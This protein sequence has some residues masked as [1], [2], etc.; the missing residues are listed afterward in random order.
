MSAEAV[1]AGSYESAWGSFPRL[2]VVSVHDLLNER[3][4]ERHRRMGHSASRT[5]RSRRS[6]GNSSPRVRNARFD[7]LGSG[8]GRP[9]ALLVELRQLI[10]DAAF[11]RFR[12]AVAYATSAG[13]NLLETHETRPG[14]PLDVS[15]VVG[16]DGS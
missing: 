8:P 4:P 11:Q 13:V 10:A 6:E 9:G 12:I 2:Q 7:P 3:F 16:L 14:D 1:G 5:R 15:V